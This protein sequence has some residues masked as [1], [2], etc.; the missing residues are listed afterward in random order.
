MRLPRLQFPVWRLMLLAALTSLAVG[1]VWVYRMHR[2]SI[3]YANEARWCKILERSCGEL[4]AA[5][6]KNAQDDENLVAYVSALGN[7]DSELS[8]Y[9]KE[10]VEQAKQRAVQSR[11]AAADCATR[12]ARCAARARNYERAARYPWLGV[13]PDPPEPVPPTVTLTPD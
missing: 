2:L 1:G 12:A 8:K 7:S 6:L 11:E 4:R 10:R 5:H 9:C 13:K 3:D